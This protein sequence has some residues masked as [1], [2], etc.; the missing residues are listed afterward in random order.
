MKRQVT[1]ISLAHIQHITCTYCEK[2]FTL[3]CLPPAVAYGLVTKTN[4]KKFVLGLAWRALQDLSLCGSF[5]LILLLLYLNM[6]QKLHTPL[7]AVA[8]QRVFLQGLSDSFVLY[9]WEGSLPAG[10]DVS[11]DFTWVSCSTLTKYQQWNHS[12]SVKSIPRHLLRFMHEVFHMSIIHTSPLCVK[13]Q[14]SKTIEEELN[15][16]RLCK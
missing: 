12:D 14:R 13:A 15:S 3:I 8:A 9:F 16:H 1:L 4:H 2:D 6:L 10:N 11:I 5:I 7:T